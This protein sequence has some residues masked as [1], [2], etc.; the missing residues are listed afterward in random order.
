[1]ILL[2]TNVVSETMRPDPSVNVRGWLDAQRSE[3]LF[4]CVPVLA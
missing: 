3:D 1:M 4:L 2:D